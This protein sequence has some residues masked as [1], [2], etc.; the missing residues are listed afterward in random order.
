[1]QIIIKMIDLFLGFIW[2]LVK[3][4]LT[5]VSIFILLIVILHIRAVMR[6]KFYE[7][8]GVV[9]YPGC[10]SFFFGNMWDMIEY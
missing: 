9:L 1:M 10:K 3:V 5:C 2:L 6:M 8:Q 4:A 7:S